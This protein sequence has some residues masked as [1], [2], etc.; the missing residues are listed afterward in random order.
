LA[1]LAAAAATP[2]TPG[3]SY[4]DAGGDTAPVQPIVSA[5]DRNISVHRDITLE[6]GTSEIG[7][8]DVGAVD[9][10]PND[11]FSRSTLDR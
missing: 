11:V 4:R 6:V 8:V 3:P 10:G 2:V 9:I 7:S 5:T 1:K